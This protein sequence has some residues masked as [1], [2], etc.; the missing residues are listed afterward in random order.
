MTSNN[1]SSQYMCRPC[2]LGECVQTLLKKKNCPFTKNFL[3]LVETTLTV[4]LGISFG[5]NDY[6]KLSNVDWII[7][8][9][10]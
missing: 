4:S 9:G 6:L 2:W 3:V 1:R 5:T 7:Q 10:G 8:V